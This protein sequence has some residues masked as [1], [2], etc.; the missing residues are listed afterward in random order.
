MARR[1][2]FDVTNLRKDVEFLDFTPLDIS[3]T[4]IRKQLRISPA[5]RALVP[6]PVVQY[7]LKKG[8]YPV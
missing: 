3:S 6:E 7:I 1:P 4:Q 5:V 2:G 8:L